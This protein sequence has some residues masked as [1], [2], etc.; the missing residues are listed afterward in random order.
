[1][2]GALQKTRHSGKS[3]SGAEAGAEEWVLAI[4]APIKAQDKV[5]GVFTAYLRWKSLE[6][7]LT[8]T[9]VAQSG[10][11][12]VLDKDGRY[13]VH[14]DRSLYGKQMTDGTEL[15]ALGAAVKERKA[16]VTYDWTNPKTG[17]FES[18]IAGISYPKAGRNLQDLEWKVIAT[19]PSAEILLLPNILRTLA[20][21]AMGA[22]AVVLGLSTVF[23]GRISKPIATL[24]DMARRVADRDLTVEV[25][26]FSR[27]D[28]IGD[29]SK[30]FALMLESFR[31]Q[32]GHMLNSA[33]VLK[34]A[35][36]QIT[37][38]VSQVASGAGQ[39]ASAV[40]ETAATVEE[41]RQS[42]ET[43]GGKAK[44]LAQTARNALGASAEGREA[45]DGTIR[46]M[47]LIRDQVESVGETV[48]KLNEKSASIEHI[49]DTVSDL[50]DQS[51]LLAVNSSIEAARAGETGKGF[52][53]VAHE[54][55][56]LADQSRQATLQ[57]GNILQ[58]TR[59]WIGAVVT[60]M[61][62]VN[63]TIEGGIEQSSKTEQAIA[64][65]DRSV[66]I[67]SREAIF[68]ETASSQQSLSMDQVSSAMVSIETAM[69]Q[70]LRGVGQLEDAAEK[71][72]DLGEH[73]RT[74][75]EAYNM[76]RADSAR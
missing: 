76:G 3:D 39:V 66:E 9:K 46:G 2:V 24:A 4:A 65:L 27:S 10:Y 11:L 28:E 42:A 72:A 69:S 50:A 61:N 64:V 18:K 7:L 38:T 14:P 60:S 5:K 35:V 52:A 33:D 29:L 30:A 53:V 21:I 31:N 34:A 20:M 43:A 19:A 13:I 59:K 32:I 15:A 57:V 49:V 6:D 73:I 37:A 12:F 36:Q 44:E 56:S 22:I 68:I 48:R 55:K 25:P 26:V 75:I 58:E 54:I 70:N 67:S 45:T 62:E 47:R 63:K 17:K 51:N 1:S 40:S 16:S 41:L 74:L 8:S 71:L 23:A